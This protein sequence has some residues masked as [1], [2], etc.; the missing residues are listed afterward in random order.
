MGGAQ[1]AAAEKPAETT[2]LGLVSSPTPCL[3]AVRALKEGVPLTISFIVA[4]SDQ[5]NQPVILVAEAANTNDVQPRLVTMRFQEKNEVCQVP[6]YKT[7]AKLFDVPVDVLQNYL[8]QKQ[9]STE[10]VV[11]I[12]FGENNGVSIADSPVSFSDFQLLDVLVATADIS[13][14]TFVVWLSAQRTVAY[15]RRVLQ[16]TANPE[17]DLTSHVINS[18]TRLVTHPLYE[19]P[20]DVTFV[21]AIVSNLAKLQP[22]SPVFFPTLTVEAGPT[23]PQQRK[24]PDPKFATAL[25][26]FDKRLQK[27]QQ[28]RIADAPAVATAGPGW[29]TYATIAASLAGG[30]AATA[31]SVAFY[32]QKK[33]LQEELDEARD[34]VADVSEVVAELRALRA[35]APATLQ[36]ELLT[37]ETELRSATTKVGRRARDRDLERNLK[38]DPKKDGPDD[39]PSLD[40]VMLSEPVVVGVPDP[41]LSM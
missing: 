24:Q 35:K 4:T 41:A 27:Q 39:S 13:Q 36:K 14:I 37:I 18:T 20:E 34:M 5:D 15:A 32:R 23:Q 31:T 3:A 33:Q 28:L 40:D 1:S 10:L 8:E 26:E 16:L 6:T 2:G 11:E 29:Q 21:A 25:Q 30:A 17:A 19:F 7:L 22:K 38:R 12:T 9:P